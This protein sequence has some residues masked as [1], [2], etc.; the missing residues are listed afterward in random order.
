MVPIHLV[1]ILRGRRTMIPDLTDKEIR[2][3]LNLAPTWALEHK[4]AA[5]S[6]SAHERTTHLFA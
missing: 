4:A 6:V 1:G 2:A 5:C 3:G